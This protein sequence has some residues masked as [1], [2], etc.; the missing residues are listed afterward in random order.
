[1]IYARAMGF[2]TDALIILTAGLAFLLSLRTGRILPAVLVCW[3]GLT[4]QVLV[5]AQAGAK[6]AMANDKLCSLFPEGTLIVAYGLFGWFFGLPIGVIGKWIYRIR[7]R[8]HKAM[9]VIAA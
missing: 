4:C 7:Q 8:R 3:I 9:H 1:M 5:L 6:L 2:G